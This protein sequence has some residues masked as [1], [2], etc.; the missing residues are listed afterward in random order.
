M[1][2]SNKNDQINDATLNEIQEL[3]PNDYKNPPES[4]TQSLK[5]SLNNSKKNSPESTSNKNQND[6]SKTDARLLQQK[7]ADLQK[8]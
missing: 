2:S 7:L 1:A 3:F 8:A 4:T 6:G 5:D